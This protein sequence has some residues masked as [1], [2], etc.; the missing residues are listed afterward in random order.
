MQ[1]SDCQ[2]HH[3]TAHTPLESVSVMQLK[4]LTLI[5]YLHYY[6]WWCVIFLPNFLVLLQSSGA[7]REALQRF[8]SDLNA[9]PVSSPTWVGYAPSLLGKGKPSTLPAQ[10]WK[11]IPHPLV[12]IPSGEAVIAPSAFL[13]HFRVRTEHWLPTK[14]H[15]S[16]TMMLLIV[17]VIGS[18]CCPVPGGAEKNVKQLLKTPNL[19]SWAVKKPGISVSRLRKAQWKLQGFKELLSSVMGW[20][21]P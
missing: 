14:Q 5:S 9:A 6:I 11:N 8:Q 21:S 4:R 16:L 18:H 15:W 19:Q 1:K 12:L 20:Q 7:T 13:L 2:I 10:R 17:S 3:S